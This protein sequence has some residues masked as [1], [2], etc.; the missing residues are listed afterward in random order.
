[1]A[2]TNVPR[3]ERGALSFAVNSRRDQQVCT[4]FEPRPQEPDTFESNGADAI[5]DVVGAR[6]S[7]N[8]TLTIWLANSVFP[9]SSK[10]HK[11]RIVVNKIYFNGRDGSKN[12]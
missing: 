6:A 4:K 3:I 2:N 5:P 9:L 7:L 1:M 11:Y 12:E 8:S 10:D